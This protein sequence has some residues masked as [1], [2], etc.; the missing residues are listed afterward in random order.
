[1]SAPLVQ[2]PYSVQA[3]LEAPNHVHAM[4]SQILSF[5]PGGRRLVVVLANHRWAERWG[6]IPTRP[7]S[8]V[9]VADQESWRELVADGLVLPPM[10]MFCVVW[11]DSVPDSSE[12]LVRVL[13]RNVLA[14][15][16][17]FRTDDRLVPADRERIVLRCPALK[18]AAGAA[19]PP[20]RRPW[21]SLFDDLSSQGLPVREGG[22]KSAIPVESEPQ[23]RPPAV[24]A[25]GRRHE[26]GAWGRSD[27]LGVF[28]AAV[29]PSMTLPPGIH[30]FCERIERAA[31]GDESLVDLLMWGVY[32]HELTHAAF[33]H[34]SGN[35]R[36]LPDAFRPIDLEEAVCEAAAFD[37]LGLGHHP[38]VKVTGA[39]FE[40]PWRFDRWRRESPLAPYS[41][42]VRLV[43]SA[44]SLG[45][46]TVR[47]VVRRFRLE[48][49]D[50]IADARTS[51]QKVLLSRALLA[52][53]R[54][55]LD[56]TVEPGAVLE[57][58]AGEG[59]GLGGTF[60]PS[61]VTVYLWGA[62]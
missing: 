12:E 17:R 55:L 47:R 24:P 21:C 43:P 28:V 7:I 45:W 39:R 59:K 13:Q 16:V 23:R 27:N 25:W 57:R 35:V 29:T 58:W 14:L 22:D 31:K 2:I 19:C 8:V 11:L 18:K 38:F 54:D 62:R 15:S 10:V 9:E 41:D 32:W 5:E 20:L 1:M 49:P 60:E 61:S 3:E 26:D 44:R 50:A 4:A 51:K 37:A 52:D 36:A 56:G 53:V 34:D 40:N 42:F 46:E 33:R 30:L 48:A 6:V